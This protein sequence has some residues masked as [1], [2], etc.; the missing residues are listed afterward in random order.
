MWGVK[1]RDEVSIRWRDFFRV[2]SSVWVTLVCLVVSSESALIGSSSPVSRSSSL[3]NYILFSPLLSFA[4][5]RFISCFAYWNAGLWRRHDH[6]RSAWAISAWSY[7]R[8]FVGQRWFPLLFLL[9][10]HRLE[11]NNQSIKPTVERLTYIFHDSSISRDPHNI[12]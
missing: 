7:T 3:S 11:L 6:D 1:K 2:F 5:P 8:I 10:H 12:G 4:S 9:H